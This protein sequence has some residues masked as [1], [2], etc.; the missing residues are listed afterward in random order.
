MDATGNGTVDPLD[1]LTIINAIGDGPVPMPP[2]FLGYLDTNANGQIDPLDVLAV[3]FT[4]QARSMRVENQLH[5]D[6]RD[7]L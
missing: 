4:L 7:C 6:G 2:H 3:I 5:R 1:V